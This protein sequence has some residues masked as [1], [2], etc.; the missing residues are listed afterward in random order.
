[1]QVNQSLWTSSPDGNFYAI[2]PH[3]TLALTFGIVFVAMVFC[4][5]MGVKNFWGE[6]STDPIPPKATVDALRD[7]LTL[8]NLGGG[9]QA[10]CNESDDAFS[11]VRRHLHHATFYGF[12]L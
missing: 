8:K 5:G 9:H 12:M 3:N 4:L 6:I 7:T 10:G 1:M 2:F 11:L